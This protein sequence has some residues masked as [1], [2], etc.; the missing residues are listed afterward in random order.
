MIVKRFI[1]ESSKECLNKNVY[2]GKRFNQLP[3]DIAKK[4]QIKTL[5]LYQ[6]VFSSCS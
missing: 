1:A 6:I 4:D 3:I 5:M 2:D